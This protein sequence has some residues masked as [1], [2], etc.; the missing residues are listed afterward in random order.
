MTKREAMEITAT[1][2][3]LMALGVS[4]GDTDALRRIS[5][6]LHRWHERECGTDHGCIERDEETGKPYAL[7][8][9]VQGDPR[10]CALYILTRDQCDDG[11][12]DSLYTQGVAV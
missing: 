1:Q 9:Y 4:R 12:I 6:T 2:N 7:R 8:A 3:R 5:L 10:G 11:R